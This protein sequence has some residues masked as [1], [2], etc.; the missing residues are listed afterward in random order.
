MLRI[1]DGPARPIWPSVRY[2]RCGGRRPHRFRPHRPSATF[3]RPSPVAWASASR[4]RPT[5]SISVSLPCSTSACF[6]SYRSTNRARSAWSAIVS[7]EVTIAAPPDPEHRVERRCVVRAAP[8]P[9][10]PSPPHPASRMSSARPDVSP[11]A[12]REGKQQR[13]APEPAR[14]CRIS[15]SSHHRRRHLRARHPRR[16]SPGHGCSPPGRCCRSHRQPSR[17]RRPLALRL[18]SRPGLGWQRDWR[19]RARAS[20]HSRDPRRW[21]SDGLRRRL[22]DAGTAR[23]GTRSRAVGPGPAGSRPRVCVRRCHHQDGHS[24]WAARPCTRSASRFHRLRRGCRAEIWPGR[25]AVFGS[26]FLLLLLLLTLL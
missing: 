14:S 24:C 22:R 25:L 20:R 8:P 9:R 4:S 2:G 7:L 1:H 3:R 15:V 16:R 11:P 5:L 19:L 6:S 13:R 26:V 21:P 17:T 23:T 10:M 12:A 18:R